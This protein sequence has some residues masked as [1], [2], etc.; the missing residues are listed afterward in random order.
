MNAEEAKQEIRRAFA[1]LG[2]GFEGGRYESDPIRFQL[3]DDDGDPIGDPRRIP[4][5][6]WKDR[7]LLRN[8]LWIFRDELL[9]SGVTLGHR[10]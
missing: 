8:A 6:T 2:C 10:P 5:S 1:P 4:A 3:S 7:E 9:A